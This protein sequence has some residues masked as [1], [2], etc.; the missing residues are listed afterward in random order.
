MLSG[1][2]IVGAVPAHAFGFQGKVS[3]IELLLLL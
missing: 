2:T 1:S 3:V